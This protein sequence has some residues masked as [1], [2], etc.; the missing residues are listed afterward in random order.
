MDWMR[1]CFCADLYDLGC[2]HHEK[3][4][5]RFNVVSEE[6][7]LQVEEDCQICVRRIAKFI[8]DKKPK[9]TVQEELEF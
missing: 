1:Q 6:Y 2:T 4:S 3:G 7:Q 8:P 5:F 9:R